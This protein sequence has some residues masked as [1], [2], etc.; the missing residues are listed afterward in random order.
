V[1]KMHDVIQQ[2]SESPGPVIKAINYMA[3]FFGIGSALG[4]VNLVVGILS[5]LW[6]MAQLYG[7]VKYELPHKR[8]KLLS[9]QRAS[10]VDLRES[11][12]GGLS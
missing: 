3:A 5:A 2:T 8:A 6:L 1:S 11:E 4:F 10:G 9:A 12:R 7:Y